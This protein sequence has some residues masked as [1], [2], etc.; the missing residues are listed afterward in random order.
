[1]Q[2]PVSKS[3]S[4]LIC[5]SDDAAFPSRGILL[6]VTIGFVTLVDVKV[7][8]H[9]ILRVGVVSVI[10][11]ISRFLERAKKTTLEFMKQ[12]SSSTEH[13]DKNIY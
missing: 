12:D 5:F 10:L 9:L 6:L 13:C 4:Y 2:Y 8:V 3:Y 7:A 11:V 1:M